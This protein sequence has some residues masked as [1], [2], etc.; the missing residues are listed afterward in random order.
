MRR[1]LPAP[2]RVHLHSV[3]RA[4][5][6]AEQ[7]GPGA[8][9]DEPAPTGTVRTARTAVLHAHRW[10]GHSRHRADSTPRRP[11]GAPTNQPRQDHC[12]HPPVLT[13]NKYRSREQ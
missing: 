3:R 5:A 4:G 1:R 13:A 9:P 2:E 8:S 7:A 10:P 6:L 12:K 11:P